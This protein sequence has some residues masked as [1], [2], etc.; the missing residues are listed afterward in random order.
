MGEFK[1]L[2]DFKRMM[3]GLEKEFQ[4]NFDGPMKKEIFLEF[5]KEKL[6]K[7]SDFLL[8]GVTNELALHKDLTNEHITRV[9]KELRTTSDQLIQEKN[10]V[11]KAFSLYQ[12]DKPE[13]QAKEKCFKDQ[14][15]SLMMDREKL[16]T[17]LKET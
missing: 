12:T 5:Y 10:S 7:T 8:H 11:Q 4:V 14:V 13:F 9:E 6:F 17:S 1:D 16:E 3:K 15:S 2:V